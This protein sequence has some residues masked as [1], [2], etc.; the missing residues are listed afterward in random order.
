MSNILQIFHVALVFLNSK[1]R[2]NAIGHA[3]ALSPD[4]SGLN[5]PTK[6]GAGTSRRGKRCLAALR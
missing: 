1:I 6:Q 5:T 3:L 4:A 2:C